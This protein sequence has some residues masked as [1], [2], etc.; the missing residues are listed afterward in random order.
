MRHR[1]A[2]QLGRRDRARHAGHDVERNARLPK[3]QRLFAAAAE[4]ERVAALEPN[5]APAAAGG[6]NHHRLNRLLRH[7]FD[8]SRRAIRAGA[9]RFPDEEPLRLP[10]VPQNP[11]VDERIVQHEIRRAQARDRLPREQRRIARARADERHV[12]R[13]ADSGQGSQDV[14]ALR[15][16]ASAAASYAGSSRPLQP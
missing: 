5:D 4:H 12:A 14:Q 8:A 15:L 9:A 11:V 2:S 13:R 1:N 7:R 10:R 3:R 6:A 16:Q